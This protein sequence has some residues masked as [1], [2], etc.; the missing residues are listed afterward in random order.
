MLVSSPSKK[1]NPTHATEAEREGERER[2]VRELSSERKGGS[3]LRGSVEP[4]RAV[5]KR[6]TK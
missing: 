6:I 4:E 3:V 1:K 2:G 5:Q